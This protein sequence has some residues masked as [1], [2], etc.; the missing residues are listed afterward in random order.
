MISPLRSINDLCVFL[1]FAS[2]SAATAL[3][4]S[5]SLANAST[6]AKVVAVA[7]LLFRIVASIY[8]PFSVNALGLV[9]E[10]LRWGKFS[11][12][13]PRALHVFEVI[14]IF[15]NPIFEVVKNFDH[16]VLPRPVFEVV[17]KFDHL[18]FL[19]F[20][21]LEYVTGRKF[22]GVIFNGLVDVLCF[23]AVQLCN[24]T[25]ENDFLPSQRNDF[26]FNRI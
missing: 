25:V 12:T 8:N 14:K 13:S 19:L 2:E 20:G 16:L 6:I 4:S 18:L 11:T 26:L 21:Q 5:R 3:E 1:S 23:H 17:E 24:T 7:C 22:I 10:N 15:D 9:G